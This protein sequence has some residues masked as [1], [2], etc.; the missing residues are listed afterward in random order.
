LGL[1]TRVAALM[2]LPVLFSALV[3]VKI[4]TG[5]F[6]MNSDFELAFMVFMLLLFFVVQGSGLVS[7]D[8][9]IKKSYN[10][11]SHE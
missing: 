11:L 6:S 4:E 9:Y 2:N 10:E 1:F 3:F 5:F 7:L 8:S